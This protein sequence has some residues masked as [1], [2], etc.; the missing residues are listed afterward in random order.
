MSFL[1]YL[2]IRL[3][4]TIGKQPP[5]TSE[6]RSKLTV[7]ARMQRVEGAIN[8]MGQTMENIYTLLKNI[9]ERLD[10]LSTNNNNMQQRPPRSTIS[11]IGVKFSSVKEEI[12]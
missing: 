12:P 11:N 1:L 5:L 7:L 10:R 2:L 6:D 9:D 3:E 4:H 8:D